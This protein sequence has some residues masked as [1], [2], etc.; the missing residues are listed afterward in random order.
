MIRTTHQTPGQ[1]MTMPHSAIPVTDR[2]RELVA[3]IDQMKGQ[4]MSINVVKDSSEEIRAGVELANRIR[5]LE[6]KLGRLV[7]GAS[8]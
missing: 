7:V 3:D 4:L 5:D 8:R 1:G 2:M 6:S